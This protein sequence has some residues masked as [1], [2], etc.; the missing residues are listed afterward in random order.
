MIILKFETGVRVVVLTANFLE[1]D[2]TG[3]SQAA[4]YQEFPKRETETCDFEVCT[5]QIGR[6]CMY[7]PWGKDKDCVRGKLMVKWSVPRRPG[8]Q[9]SAFH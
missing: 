5:P 8:Q 7:G 1:C 9:L 2:V 3:K 6:F 4:W